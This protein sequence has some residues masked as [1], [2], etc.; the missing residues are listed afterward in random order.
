MRTAVVEAETR[1]E[2]MNEMEGR[3]RQME[4]M[5]Q[6]RLED[7]AL[8]YEEKL[9]RKMELFG[10][11]GLGFGQAGPSRY[12]DD[13]DMDGYDSEEAEELDIEKSLTQDAL[14][15][16]SPEPPTPLLS[17]GALPPITPEP[18]QDNEPSTPIAS[19]SMTQLPPPEPEDDNPIPADLPDLDLGVDLD[20]P[21]NH[22]DDHADK[23]DMATRVYD[24]SDEEAD[25]KPPPP[26]KPR[27]S[28][29]A[30][31]VT[32]AAPV[33][34]AALE[35]GSA[36]APIVIDLDDDQPVVLTKSHVKGKGISLADMDDLDDVP[37]ADP[38]RSGIAVIPNRKARA[39][40][41]A[42]GGP[43][44]TYIPM[45]G[46]VDTIKKKKRSVRFTTV[47]YLWF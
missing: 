25:Y 24:S 5:F 23:E 31:P 7:A 4:A 46:E 45:K 42:H 27:H 9:A 12:A 10:D 44:V 32:S 34:L 39:A 33:P 16:H 1:E 14:L 11:P 47:D 13:V 28:K 6:A 38:D 3:M 2:V 35:K 20:S 43:G 21:T 41:I 19:G 36:K 15:A 17:G 22:L 37:D 40:A 26:K 30:A 8:A 18:E 29:P